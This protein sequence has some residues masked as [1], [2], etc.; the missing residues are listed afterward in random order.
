MNEPI[1]IR[2]AQPEDAEVASVLLHS[3]YTHQQE[4]YPLPE[5][6]ENRFLKYL[7]HFFRTAGNRF[8]YQYIQVA[9]H[10]G[11]VIGLVLS[12]A[13]K[14]EERLNAATGW[15]LER[16]AEDDEWYVDALAV[17]ANWGR[18]GIGT[19]L[20]QTAEQLARRYHY[21]KIALHVARENKQARSFY[22]G[23]QYG[24]TQQTLLY[25]RPYVRMVKVLDNSQELLD[26][27]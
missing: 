22:H 25:Q 14:D 13:G 18:K 5:E 11:S 9:E 19:H 20:L 23:L 26:E 7:Q 4:T 1:K 16:E 15:Q 6:H 3:A 17:L 27:L 12:F 8:S 21:T 2:P 24:V 10:N